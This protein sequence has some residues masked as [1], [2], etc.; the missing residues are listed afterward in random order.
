MAIIEK[1]NRK[2]GVKYCAR[3][4]LKGQCISKTFERKSDAQRWAEDTEAALRA[5]VAY[6]GDAPPGDMSFRV[7]LER[8]MDD[9]SAKKKPTTHVREEASARRLLDFFSQMT[10][11]GILSAD[12]A[13]Y[14]DHRAMTVGASTIRNELALLSHLY[15]VAIMEWSLSVANPVAGIRKPS[16]PRGRTRFLSM[17]ESK[18]LLAECRKSQN[19]N[20]PL[21]FAHASHRHAAERGGGAKV[22]GRGHRTP[23]HQSA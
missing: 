10:L 4:R 1:R 7:A 12:V 6:I 3:V 22:G 17:D 23:D 21:C 18:R 11:G 9:V 8:Y 19:K 14:R 5:G 20:L 15:S 16:L 13:R 2:N